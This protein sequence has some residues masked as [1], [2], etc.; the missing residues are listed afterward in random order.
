MSSPVLYV[1]GIVP[2]DERWVEMKAVY[3]AC[4][5]AE[6]TLPREVCI[7][8]DDEEPDPAGVI[9]DLDAKKWRGDER[10]GLEIDVADLPPHVKTIRFIVS[11]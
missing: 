11:Y 8:F 2:P 9:I 1:Q 10:V 6:I 7:F 5:K 3:D 4:Q